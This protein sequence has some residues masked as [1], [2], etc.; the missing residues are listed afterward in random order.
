MLVTI[1]LIAMAFW[2]NDKLET[3]GAVCINE[4]RSTVASKNRDGYFGSDY[5]ELYNSSNQE[6]NLDGWY[7]SDDESNL[8]KNRISGV[9][10][11]ANSYAVFYSNS[12]MEEEDYRINF[13]VSSLGE[14]IFLSN[15]EGE[16]VDSILVPELRYGEVY[17]RDTDG[18]NQWN[19]K[20]ES[21]ATS[22]ETAK[23]ITARILNNPEFSHESGFYD[24]PFT[25]K[26]ECQLGQKVY[27]TLDG[28]VPTMDSKEYIDGIYI[29]NISDQPNVVT[30]VKNVITEWEDYVPSNEKN[31]KAVVVR[32]VVFDN[33][34]RS[35]EVITHT[36]FVGL[37]QYKDKNIV[38]VV[39][40]Y[41]D[42]FGENGI[43][44]TG[45]DYDQAYLSGQVENLP[46]PNFVKSGRQWEVLGNLQFFSNGE[47]ICNQEAGI[48][49]YGGS[50]RHAKIKRMSFYARNSYSGNEFFEGLTL[51]ERKVSSMGTN[52]NLGNFILPQL[53]LDRAVAVQGAAKT[54]IFLNGEYYSDHN[55]MEKYSDQFFE[56]RYGISADNLLVIRDGELSKGTW[57]QFNLYQWL[58]KQVMTKDMSVQENYDEVSSLMDIQS[59]ID[60]I[61]TNVYLCNM[62]VTDVKNYMLWRCVKPNDSN[63]GDGKFRW[64]LYDM[65][66]LDGQISKSYY[67]VN[68]AAEVNSFNTKGRYV[69]HA[70]NEELIYKALINNSSYR[71]QFVL[72][73]MDM[74][75]VNFEINNVKKV[76]EQ[77][78][79]PIEQFG[80]FF[81]KRFDCIVPY[82]ADEF[83]LTGTLENVTLKIN[84]PKAGRIK[85]NTT[86]PN[87]ENGSWIG[88][89]Y[90]DYPVMVTAE[91]VEG[92][93]FVGWTGSIESSEMAIEVE[94]ADN[95]IVLEAVFEKI[96]N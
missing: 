95:G 18:G 8:L 64:M 40:D 60:Y 53:A 15:S 67:K 12:E 86:I 46:I 25:L 31:D 22:N 4:V 81:E 78:N 91:A 6:V 63:Y 35:S 89:Y 90:T 47:A 82:M 88:K 5:I 19:I 69:G 51:G 65:G 7:L 41:E 58:L 43:F 48:R 93:Q 85:I 50:N 32:A 94:I 62:D 55:V 73:F 71:K 3:N 30:A 52:S 21:L 20:E 37:D 96:E 11:A 39:A 74:A 68:S 56:Q 2:C 26:V 28:S 80:D 92:Y 33:K 57:E 54:I 84:D 61:C 45:K 42:L 70:I 13:K 77:W 59:Y 14:K 83:G 36:Y 34:N 29:E 23:H 24:E 27:Y 17:A 49:T 72:S 44:V 76:F 75:N 79:C 10:I 66:S 16:L 9:V 87:L 1:M 38:S